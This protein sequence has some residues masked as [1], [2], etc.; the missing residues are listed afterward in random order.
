MDTPVIDQINAKN[1]ED[2]DALNSKLMR[3]FAAHA[4]GMIFIRLAV[5]NATVVLAKKAII[6]AAKRV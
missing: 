1:Q 6:E 5:R 3:R 4:V 2:R